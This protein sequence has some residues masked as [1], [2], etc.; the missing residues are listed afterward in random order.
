MDAA[1]LVAKCGS[2][3]AQA[4]LAYSFVASDDP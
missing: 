2:G 3:L 1:G 4:E